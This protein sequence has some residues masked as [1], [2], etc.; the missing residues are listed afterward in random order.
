M[1]IELICGANKLFIIG[2][3]L[4]SANVHFEEYKNVLA[5]VFDLFDELCEIGPVL[6]CGDF[7][8]DF[9]N[10]ATTSKSKLL[11]ELMHDRNLCSIFKMENQ[12][13]FQTKDETSKSIID[14]ILVPEWL[15]CEIQ[16]KEIFNDFKYEISDHSP[17]FS[18]INISN[19]FQLLPPDMSRNIPKWSSADSKNLKDFTETTQHLLD[20]SSVSISSTDDIDQHLVHITASLVSAADQHIPYG[21]V[22]PYLKPYWKKSN[23]QTVHYEMRCARRIWKSEGSPRNKDSTSYVNY[24]TSKRIFKQKHRQ[25]RKEWNLSIFD[26]ID[27]AAEIDIGTFY[28]TAWRNFNSDSTK[29]NLQRHL[30]RRCPKHM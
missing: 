30:S 4:P 15:E 2:C 3:L 27:K 5:E 20:K 13:T 10:K 6:I 22:R 7:N 9:I 17:L 14:Y 16:Y 28:K 26:E 12:Y 25:A 18:E 29:I 11:V 24:K 21:K 1:S 19:I 23:L 8:T